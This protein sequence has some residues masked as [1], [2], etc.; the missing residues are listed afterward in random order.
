[1]PDAG[2]GVASLTEFADAPE[3]G[4]TLFV[5][6]RWLPG[7]AGT[8]K[9]DDGCA[10][11]TP[12]CQVLASDGE[13]FWEGN[14]A[15]AELAAGPL[16]G[17]WREPS[18]VNLLRAS[19]AARRADDGG[20]PGSEAWWAVQAGG[21]ALELTVRF[22]YPEGAVTALRCAR[23]LPA[24]PGRS[25]QSF[26]DL[27]LV[28]QTAADEAEAATARELCRLEARE[29]VV[30]RELDSCPRDS[31]AEERRL[32]AEFTKVLNSQ[33]RKIRR[34]WY[35]RR[36]ENPGAP[37]PEPAAASLAECL[38]RRDEDGQHEAGDPDTCA[39]TGNLEIGFPSLAFGS[40]PVPSATGA[41][42]LF[43]IPLTIGMEV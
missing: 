24:A 28:A 6:A 37:A 34:L 11:E 25:L 32:V 39:G 7:L 16:G 35:A 9:S 41:T 17:S 42:N 33:K 20:S 18:N 4:L 12:A 43:T 14:I 27:A 30:R 2:D 22:L 15:H 38:D 10:H 26:V 13:R 29:E 36:Q 5:Y 19:L 40:A 8:A 1:M 21:D 3:P 23:F 31:E